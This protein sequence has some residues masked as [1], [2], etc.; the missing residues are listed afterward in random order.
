MIAFGSRLKAGVVVAAAAVL[1]GDPAAGARPAGPVTVTRLASPETALRFEVT[2]PGTLDQVWAAFTTKDGL[3]TWLWR[4]V[5][6]EARPGGDW[7]VIFPE[8]TGGGTIVSL[9]P[10]TQLVIAALAPEKFPTVRKD[11]TTA[12]FRF[13]AATPTSTTVT[14]TQTGWKTGAE[15]DAAYEYLADGNAELLTQ[16]YQ[17]F[18]SGP[19]AWPK[20]Q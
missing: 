6:V 13:R 4:D 3:A 8:S 19:I 16:L 7:L 15:W 20:G 2:V 12:T 14:L 18:V 10:K 9:A 11:R 17:R 5:R 1:V